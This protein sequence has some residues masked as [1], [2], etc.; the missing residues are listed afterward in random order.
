MAKPTDQRSTYYFI[1][2]KRESI[3]T[4]FDSG[5][6]SLNSYNAQCLNLERIW[7]AD[8]DFEDVVMEARQ[9]WRQKYSFIGYRYSIAGYVWG[10]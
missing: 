6:V 3:V 5:W 10:F 9:D 8:I 4:T 1:D 7:I 2:I